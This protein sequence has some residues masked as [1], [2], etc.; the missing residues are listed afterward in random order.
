MCS[1]YRSAYKYRFPEWPPFFSV[2]SLTCED[3]LLSG[4]LSGLRCLDALKQSSSEL[5][6]L[7][8]AVFYHFET[9]LLF[10][11]FVYK[12]QSIIIPG[13]SC[14]LLN[15][16]AHRSASSTEQQHRAAEQQR[17]RRCRA[18]PC[19]AMPCG[20]MPCGAVL[21]GAVPCCAVLRAVLYLQ[22]RTCMRSHLTK[23]HPAVPR[24]ITPGLYVLYC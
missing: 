5:S 10:L 14:A 9:W 4:P 23:Y 19:G 18:M 16:V 8:N 1:L 17:R 12:V 20:A 15:S 13:P 3:V 11:A 7:K 6:H 24:Y 22:F 2:H 21:C